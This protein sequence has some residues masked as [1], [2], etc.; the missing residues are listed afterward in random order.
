[1]K[2]SILTRRYGENF[3]SSLQ[4][5]ALQKAIS[6]IT[7][8]NVVLDY[9]EYYHSV[10]WQIRPFVY[11]VLFFM[12]KTFHLSWLYKRLFS[13]LNQRDVQKTKFKEFDDLLMKTDKKL[14]TK[15]ELRKACSN[16][17][18]C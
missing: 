5:Y 2:V 6:R 18:F 8:D 12:L 10:R 7:T 9:D 13:F 15:S 4:A 1:M 14:R 17:D 16:S 3:G 11:D